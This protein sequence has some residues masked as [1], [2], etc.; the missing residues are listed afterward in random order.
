MAREG[1]RGM[2]WCLTVPS[3]LNVML[4]WWLRRVPFFGYAASSG[5]ALS[6]PKFQRGIVCS[7]SGT[8]WLC[9]SRG[10]RLAACVEMAFCKEAGACTFCRKACC[11]K[12]SAVGR[13]VGSCSQHDS[14]PLPNIA[15]TL[16]RCVSLSWSQLRLHA[17][18]A[19]D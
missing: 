13:R 9:W 12:P 6:V 11:N 17:P 3:S 10:A 8:W 1:W 5:A 16:V 14:F 18:V 7:Y 19:D 4:I 2:V 15:C